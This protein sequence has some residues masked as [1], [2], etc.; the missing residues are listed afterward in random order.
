MSLSID[1]RKNNVINLQTKCYIN[2]V[3]KTDYKP[4][5]PPPYK[6]PP[7]TPFPPGIPPKSAKKLLH[8]VQYIYSYSTW[9]YPVRVKMQQKHVGG[10]NIGKCTLAST[11]VGNLSDVQTDSVQH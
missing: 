10:G 3:H 4:T 6:G 2:F 5:L 11:D 9:N 8:T 7:S 1:G